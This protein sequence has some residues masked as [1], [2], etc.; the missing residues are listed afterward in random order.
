MDKIRNKA[1]AR[2][3]G[4]FGASGSGKTTK[5]LELVKNIDRLVVFDPLD[6]FSYKFVKFTDIKTLKNAILKNYASGFKVRFVPNLGQAKKQLS[7]I[8]IFLRQLQAGYKFSKFSSLVTLYVDE[9]DLGFPLNE[10][11]ADGNNGFYY[12][13]CRG[14]HYGINIVGV[15]QRMSLVDLPFRA[16]LSD[17]Y[18][19]RL[20]DFNDI[21]SACAMIGNNYKSQIQVLQNYRYIYKNPHGEITIK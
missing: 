16:N 5:A 7:E 20:A 10:S 4:I 2:R 1:Q 12:L 11:R 13:C 19:F 21:K 17:M 9:L 8:C 14:R 6:E 18:I 3:V 15:S